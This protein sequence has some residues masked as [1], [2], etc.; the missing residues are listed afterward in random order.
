MHQEDGIFS[1]FGELVHMSK[2][3]QQEQSIVLDTR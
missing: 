2:E 1:V 3:T